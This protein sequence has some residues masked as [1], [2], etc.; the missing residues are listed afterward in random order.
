M[1]IKKLLRK[2]ILLSLPDTTGANLRTLESGIILNTL[3]GV[4]YNPTHGTVL[5]VADGVTDVQ[6]GDNV[7]FGNHIWENA[8]EWIYG[9]SEAMYRGHYQGHT[10]WALEEDGKFYL[11]LPSR[12]LYMALRGTDI[13][14]LNGH[15][16]AE[17]YKKSDAGIVIKDGGKDVVLNNAT[18]SDGGII[19]PDL[20]EER[21][22]EDMAKIVVAPMGS[23]LSTGDVVYTLRHCDIPV[24]EPLNNPVLPKL[25][26]FIE[27]ENIIAKQA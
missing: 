24:E 13:V 9:A 5:Q 22:H 3:S 4:R 20:A 21:Y 16:I 17:P 18:V 12:D 15:V 25:Y 23:D 14:P 27:E 10:C 26:F 19:L 6:V 1:D 2:D 11:I 8:K 7:F